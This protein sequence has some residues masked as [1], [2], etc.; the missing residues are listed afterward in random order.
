ME[1]ITELEKGYNIYQY[2]E[3]FKFSVDA[4]L[5]ADFIDK[6]KKEKALEIGSGTG[7]IPILLLVKDKVENSKIVALELQEKMYQLIQ[8]NITLN[9]CADMIEAI[10]IDVKNY[11]VGNSYDVVFS[12]PPYMVVDGKKKNDNLGRLISRHEVTLDLDDLVK[13][14]KRLLKPIGKFYMVHR[15]H[16]LQEI[17][18]T[19]AKYD[20]NIEKIQFVYH[21]QGEKSNL[22]LI[23][24][25]KGIKKILEVQ[26]PKY[27]S[28]F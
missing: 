9:N 19:L 1:S 23:K 10:N 2:E 11:N 5:L 15:T 18:T 26:E 7:I 13:H 17:I 3:E 28:E 22:V 16:R 24:A 21:K 6:I 27:I 4:V 14:G 20:F 8:K 12:N 25:N